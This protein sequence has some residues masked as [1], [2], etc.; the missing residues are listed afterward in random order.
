MDTKYKVLLLVL[1]ISALICLGLT[2]LP[3]QAFLDIQRQVPLTVKAQQAKLAGF[4]S[5]VEKA[6]EDGFVRLI[7][8][9]N[10]SFK[11][12]GELHSG[13]RRY[14]QR[15]FISR[16]Q[17]QIATRLRA[18][19]A[20]VVWDF[21]F[22][23]YMIVEVDANGLADLASNPIVFS[24]QEDL[25]QAPLL[26][27]SVPLI[28][29]DT[30]WN[31][32]HSD[33]D[34]TI[35]VLDT[36]VESS[37][38]ILDGK[39]I[40]EA[41]FSATTG[42]K[43]RSTSLCPDGSN[44]QI[45]AGAGVNC[46]DGISGCTHGTLVA[47]VAAGDGVAVSGV[48]KDADIISVQ[49]FSEFT[50][51][52]C[53][54]YNMSSP[55]ALSWIS[56]QIAALEWIYTIHSDYN[57]AAVNMS[58]GGGNYSEYCDGDARKHSIDN[59]R[60]VDIATVVAAGD[61]GL[62][63]AVDAPACISSTVSVGSTTDEDTLQ[64]SSNVSSFLSLLAPGEAFGTSVPN[65]GDGNIAGTSV[66]AGRVS[67]AWALI[68][69][70]QP[71]ASVDQIL[72][73]LQTTGLRLNDTRSDGVITN[74]PR[75]QMDIALASFDSQTAVSVEPPAAEISATP[76]AVEIPAASFSYAIASDMR[77]Y[78]GSGEYNTPSYFRGAVEAIGEWGAT[79]FMIIPGDMDHPTYA[80]WTID[81][82]IGDDYQWYPVVGNHDLNW[83]V[84]SWIMAYDKGVINPGPSGCPDT[85]YSFDYE[86]AHFVM[87]N[88]YCNH[89]GPRSTD[90]DI[91]DH[92]YDWLAA[93]LEAADKAHVFVFGHE[94]A[95]PQPDAESGS[96]RHEDN[97]LNAY[98]ENRDRFWRLL[99][100]YDVA[101]YGCGH[102]HGFSLTQTDGVW[103]LDAGH[104]SGLGYSNSPSTFIIIT[105]F[106]DYVQYEVYRDDGE[107]GEYQ[108]YQRG[109]LY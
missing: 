77:Y 12:E 39:V 21:E 17:N 1:S 75:I 22:V 26:L 109:N 44:Q 60:S 97:S 74:L 59:L 99:D 7:I 68:R 96:V 108:L 64:A 10:V 35:V 73:A 76:T 34:Q 33:S 70:E 3:V 13:L 79:D 28:G 11:P 45:G 89:I 31:L 40:A 43:D 30:A 23:P 82:Y 42:E 67:A 93:D 6:Q 104:A 32:G 58:L 91:S 18:F 50:D 19:R 14:V 98:P 92:L 55:C 103:Q 49:V 48:A 16:A 53:L 36:G 90:G 66:A 54:D 61:D 100:E 51:P 29:A 47:G 46:P 71:T 4:D 2:T 87:L 95:Y 56:D 15:F 24:I 78:A 63:E 101:F 88:V 65:D 62:R 106:S 8:G 57:I 37:H 83:N 80:D 107:G 27:E 52:T 81:T 86:N 38:E 102:T 84:L 69:S 94:P 85:T 25:P 105:V 20:K 5:L 9:I 41:C 72:S